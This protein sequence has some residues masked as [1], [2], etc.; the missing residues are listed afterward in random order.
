MLLD[1]VAD[2]AL[3][4]REQALLALGKLAHD[5]DVAGRLWDP[6]PNPTPTPTRTL[7]LTLNP[8][9]NP[10]QVGCGTA[11]RETASSKP[12]AGRTRARPSRP[13]TS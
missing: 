13:T 12:R 10:N 6:N 3:P 7:A 1:G 5:A 11:H 8:N 4:I 9:P 2:A